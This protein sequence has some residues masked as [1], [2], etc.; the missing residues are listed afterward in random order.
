LRNSATASQ[1]F[2]FNVTAFSMLVNCSANTRWDARQG[3]MHGAPALL[4]EEW[5]V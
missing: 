3:V 4:F 2:R 1:T 5:V